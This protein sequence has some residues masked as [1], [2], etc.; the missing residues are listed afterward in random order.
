[1]NGS[2]VQSCAAGG[3]GGGGGGTDPGTS[4]PFTVTPRPGVTTMVVFA[5]AV[6]IVLGIADTPMNA[7]SRAMADSNFLMTSNVRGITTRRLRTC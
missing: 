4:A 3:A 2:G 5:C 6:A 1:M 7:N